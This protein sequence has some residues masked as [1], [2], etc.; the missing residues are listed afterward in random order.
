MTRRLAAVFPA[1][2]LLLAACAPEPPAVTDTPLPADA[3][4]ADRAG[5]AAL[6]VAQLTALEIPGL[7]AF[8]QSADPALAIDPVSGELLVA[9]LAEAR[10]EP[11]AGTG[12]WDLWFS[13]I[14][15]DHPAGALVRV[16]DIAGEPVPHAEGS[17]RLVAF[18]GGAALVWNNSIRQEGRRFN[19]SDLRFARSTDDGQ[20][21]S[22]AITL[23][24]P[25]TPLDMPRRANTF[26]GAAWD[27]GQGLVVAWLD[28][29]E[30]DA[31]RL[32]RGLASGLPESEA[33]RTPERFSDD[34][35]PH[36]SDATIFV[37]VSA[38]LG[39]SWGERNLRLEGRVCP[40]CRITLLPAADG[41]IHGAWREHFPGSQR[42]PVFRLLLR[43]GEPLAGAPLRVHEDAWEFPGCPHSGPGLALDARGTVHMT[44]YTGAPG[45][46]GV[47]YARK[48]A[49]Q[50]Q[51][52]APLPVITG[53]LVGIAHPAI[54]VR[55][56][57]SVVIAQN[58]S[59]DGRRA[60]VLT[61]LDASGRQ[62]W[63]VEAAD[64]EGSTHPQLALPADGRVVVAWTQSR[65]GM[66]SVRIAQL[67]EEGT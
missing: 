31:R 33:A 50:A 10:V 42:D 2:L 5:A 20:S 6:A 17:P 65:D 25:T 49:D 27:G 66:E 46:T 9:F 26:H 14:A 21:W 30:R 1:A 54:V 37:A 51:F 13:R 36:D 64:S 57:G 4:S 3:G 39:E 56:D 45:R 35:D 61:A 62:L 44:W 43:D 41:T 22:A 55:A 48:P 63:Q 19:A 60:I 16:N 23:Q 47:W 32:A 11:D 24:D 15:A 40:C 34:D 12:A 38:D 29:R 7:A 18:P 58:V 28:G 67:L 59:A 8:P 53:P 52:G